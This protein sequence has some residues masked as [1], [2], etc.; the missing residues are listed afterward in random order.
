[1]Q[2]KTEVV[3]YYFLFLLEGFNIRRWEKVCRR[4][5][6]FKFEGVSGDN[7]SVG[8]LTCALLSKKSFALRQLRKSEGPTSQA[9]WGESTAG[10]CWKEGSRQGAIT[11]AFR[12]IN[13]YKGT[14][15]EFPF[16]DVTFL[17][18]CTVPNCDIQKWKF[19]EGTLVPV[20]LTECSGDRPLGLARAS[21]DKDAKE[22]PDKIFSRSIHDYLWAAVHKLTR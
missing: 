20:D 4:P 8:L 5:C 2:S 3:A 10:L 12:E 17:R 13:W 18:G 9:Y 16:W 1:M 21:G 15:R 6:S 19:P 22:D 7:S 11:G 14:L